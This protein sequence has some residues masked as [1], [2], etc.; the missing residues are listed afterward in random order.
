MEHLQ[1]TGIVWFKRDLRLTDHAGLQAASVSELPILLL[2][3][4]EPDL[5]Y[6]AD[7]DYRHWAFVR[8]CLNEMNQA[9]HPS[10]TIHI[11][12]GNASDIFDLLSESRRIVKVWSYR[13][14]G[15]DVTFK[16]DIE[17]SR[18]FKNKNTEWVEFQTNGVRRGYSNRDNWTRD[19]FSYQS[20]K[21]IE[22][23]LK[24][25][26]PA[27]LPD[28]MNRFKMP[29]KKIMETAYHP[30]FQ[31]G[32]ENEAKETLNSFISER[33]VNYNNHIS[34]PWASRN[35]C[36][37]LSP[38]LAWGNLSVRQVYQKAKEA[39]QS[40]ENKKALNS[41]ISRLQWHCHFIQKFEDEPEIE[42]RNGNRGYDDIRFEQDPVKI[43]AWKTGTT[44]IPLV[45]AC[46]RCVIKTGYLNFRMRA[47]L[48][49]FL[50]HHLWHP[51]RPG[52]V[53]LAKQF[54]DFEPGIHYSQFQMQAGTLGINTIRIY[55]PVKQSLDHD[56]EGIF[57]KTWVPELKDIPSAIIHEPWK[58]TSLEQSMYRCVI[59]GDYPKP[60]IAD[61]KQSYREASSKL[62]AKKSE[63]KVKAENQ[64]ILHRHVRR[65]RG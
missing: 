48:A 16:R 60:I 52:A 59:G 33:Y 49:S 6:S 61:L 27:L 50:T 11:L 29:K 21:I 13:E 39:K 57:I 55:N 1:E 18:K 58:L 47:M 46:M 35:S 20:E 43:E 8:Q 54:L 65:G 10:L 53:H 9:L 40:A 51:W 37:R 12:Y 14:T 15:T 42:F 36:S 56:P 63:D 17:L 62:W 19:W 24:R 30:G 32:G 7:F 5:E 64:R 44:G 31:S 3:C 25:L 38:Y 22:T 41:F 45:D 26:K 34:K 23:D 4:F 2:Y 28:A